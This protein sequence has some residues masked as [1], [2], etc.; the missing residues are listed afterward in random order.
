MQRVNSDHSERVGGG[1]I[2]AGNILELAVREHDGRGEGRG[3]RN[4][5]NDN[6]SEEAAR[7]KIV[8]G[9]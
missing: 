2:A 8:L 3:L 4:K 5:G 9:A 6:P 1:T 7:W